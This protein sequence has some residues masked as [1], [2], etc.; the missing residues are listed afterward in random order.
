MRVEDRK[1]L[2]LF[3][4]LAPEQQE[5]LIAFA[6]FLSGDLAEPGSADVTAHVQ[7]AHLARK[8]RAADLAADG[9][10]TQAQF[11]GALGIAERAARLMAAN[12]DLAGGIEAGVQRLLSPTGMGQLFKAVA[13]HSPGLPPPPAFG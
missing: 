4:Q 6:E 8:A 10:M 3:E 13:V 1:L 9:P 5:R 12:P 2:E 7:F 11:L